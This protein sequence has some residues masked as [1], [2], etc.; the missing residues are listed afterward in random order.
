MRETQITNAATT[1][2]G[3]ST[4]KL[5]IAKLTNS[6]PSKSAS[7]KD[8]D[9][10]INKDEEKDRLSQELERYNAPTSF[11]STND[12]SKI[13]NKS[14]M[15]SMMLSMMMS[16]SRGGAFGNGA[17][18]KITS[19]PLSVVKA[20]DL[21]RNG[22]ITNSKSVPLTGKLLA[23]PTAP[24][25]NYNEN[26]LKLYNSMNVIEA[27]EAV[28]YGAGKGGILGKTLGESA[29]Q[30]INQADPQKKEVVDAFLNSIGSNQKL[31]DQ[32]ANDKVQVALTGYISGAAANGGA[33]AAYAN[34][35][36]SFVFN[37][38]VGW[39]QGTVNHELTHY[40]DSRDAGGMDG[41]LDHPNFYNAKGQML[42]ALNSNRYGIEA[43]LQDDFSYGFSND[44][45]FLAEASRMWQKNPQAFANEFPEMAKVFSEYYGK[46]FNNLDQQIQR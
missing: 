40:L 20:E 36:G 4:I 5:A 39:D 38:N 21:Q 17:N 41:I 6:N 28:A 46:F 42:G 18:N 10:D 31:V 7:S 37:T 3:G 11:R 32:M 27:N 15:D 24:P 34:S 16:A 35:D 1:R 30:D 13:A 12:S 9:Q 23:D 29:I 19:A 33:I 8:K 44:A 45:E 22:S 43:R 26:F 25:P 2:N 14:L